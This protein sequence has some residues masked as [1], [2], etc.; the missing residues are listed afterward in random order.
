MLIHKIKNLLKLNH[1]LEKYS[2]ESFYIFLKIKRI[3]LLSSKSN[4]S[5]FEKY[6]NENSW[7]NSESL[8][9]P[10]ST[11]KNTKYVRQILEDVIKK[12][13]IESMVDSP[14]GDFNWMKLVDFHNTKYLGYDI[15]G[16][17]IDDNNK[18][19]SSKLK[20]FKELNI[21]KN[22]PH[23]SD[24]IFCRDALVHFSNKDIKTTVSNFKKSNSKY[25]LT[26]TFPNINNNKWIKTGMWRPLNLTKQPFNFPKPIEIFRESKEKKDKSLNKYL[27][28]WKLRDIKI[29]SET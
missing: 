2:R 3:V 9:G 25:L 28:L 29:N 1:T 14:C 16:K 18:K 22:K 4:K 21:I 27:G 8:S 10:G 20:V 26:T 6:Y 12:Y 7:G 24:L 5:I 19:Y 15:V 13:G 17:I 23:K 11:I